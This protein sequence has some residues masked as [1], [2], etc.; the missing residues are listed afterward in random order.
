MT[1]VMYH[2]LF[3]YLAFNR[4]RKLRTYHLWR[5]E[6]KTCRPLRGFKPSQADSRL[7]HDPASRLSDRG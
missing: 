1:T 4:Q 2:D 5:I 7:P 6:D 3:S